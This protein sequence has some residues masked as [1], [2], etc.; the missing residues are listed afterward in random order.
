MEVG[1]IE[2]RYKVNIFLRIFRLDL[3]TVQ[4]LWYFLHYF[5]HNYSGNCN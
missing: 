4:I 1:F 2:A 3:G 5:M